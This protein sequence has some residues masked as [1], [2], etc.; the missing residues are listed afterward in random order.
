MKLN[1]LQWLWVGAAVLFVFGLLLDVANVWNMSPTY[2]LLGSSLLVVT[3]WLVMPSLKELG[4]AQ[5][6]RH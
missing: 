4:R 1:L 3:D 5:R 6:R 2:M